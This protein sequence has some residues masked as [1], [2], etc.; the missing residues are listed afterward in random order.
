MGVAGRTLRMWNS[1]L[2][3]Y[4]P[5]RG[6]KRQPTKPIMRAVVVEVMVQ[7]RAGI[8]FLPVY[9]ALS[10][11]SSARQLMCWADLPLCLQ[12]STM[13]PFTMEV[14]RR[15]SAFGLQITLWESFYLHCSTIVLLLLNIPYLHTIRT[16]I[17]VQWSKILF[18][19]LLPN[20]N[21]NF[22]VGNK[23]T[24]FRISNLT[25]ISDFSRRIW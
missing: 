22:A 14:C 3:I 8:H 23:G 10:C 6:Y 18:P 12:K 1:L 9:R 11:R 2:A 13:L 15:T 24:F 25:I 4:V 19:W 5:S 17:H 21:E 20:E 7:D 16:S